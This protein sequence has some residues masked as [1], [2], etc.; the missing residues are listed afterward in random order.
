MTREAKSVIIYLVGMS[1]VDKTTEGKILAK[2][3]GYSLFDLDN[4]IEDY[5]E[6]P[7]ERNYP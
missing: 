1:C 5:F 2:N 3:I 6:K 4:E 7:I